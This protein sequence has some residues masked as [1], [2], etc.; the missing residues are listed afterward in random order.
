M[1]SE[2]G[3]STDSPSHCRRTRRWARVLTHHALAWIASIPFVLCVNRQ[4]ARPLSELE[5]AEL[6]DRFLRQ[7]RT[8]RDDLAARVEA[9]YEAEVSRVERLEDKLRSYVAF[10]G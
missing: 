9:V 8:H 1:A 6:Q 2:D 4:H 3:G 10:I 7:L 5:V